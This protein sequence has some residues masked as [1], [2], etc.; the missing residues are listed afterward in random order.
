MDDCKAKNISIYRCQ[1]VRKYN[2]EVE[3]GGNNYQ[4]LMS[5]IDR[6]KRCPV[7]FPI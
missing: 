4:D 7:R 3:S 5:K 1:M 6:Q 2:S